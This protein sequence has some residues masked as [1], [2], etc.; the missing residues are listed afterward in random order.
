MLESLALETNGAKIPRLQIPQVYQVNIFE[1]ANPY[2]EMAWLFG[3]LVAQE[4]TVVM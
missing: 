1:M 4:S 2:R 3:L